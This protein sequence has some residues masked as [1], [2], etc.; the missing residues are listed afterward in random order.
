MWGT[1]PGE[2]WRGTGQGQLSYSKGQEELSHK[3]CVLL[4]RD[5]VHLHCPCRETTGDQIRL[6]HSL[7]VPQTL[8]GTFHRLTQMEA[9]GRSEEAGVE[10]DGEWVWAG[11]WWTLP[12]CS[13]RAEV[14]PGVRSGQAGK[15]TAWFCNQRKG[16]SCSDY[17]P[18]EVGCVLEC[19][20]PD[21]MRISGGL[22]VT[23][24]FFKFMWNGLWF[25][26]NEQDGKLDVFIQ[27]AKIVG[28]RRERQGIHNTYQHGVGYLR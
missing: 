24:F 25:L 5:A 14:C 21:T 28:S 11:R 15:P 20:M 27:R 8:V 2:W 4:E 3:S 19:H 16:N 26:G 18:T 17:I 10:K 23:W 9:G 7:L 1:Q 13:S 12:T 6:P 22:G